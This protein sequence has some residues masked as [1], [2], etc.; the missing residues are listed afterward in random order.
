MV[1]K[2]AER[3]YQPIPDFTISE[4]EIKKLNQTRDF[5]IEVAKFKVTGSSSDLEGI[6][7]D[8]GHTF[9]YLGPENE[10]D[11]ISIEE[12]QYLCSCGAVAGIKAISK[13]RDSGIFRTRD[14]G[15]LATGKAKDQSH[16]GTVIR[17]SR[18]NH[19]LGLLTEPST[20][21][22]QAADP[23]KYHPVNFVHFKYELEGGQLGKIQRANSDIS[24][25]STL[26]VIESDTNTTSMQLDPA[27]ALTSASLVTPAEAAPESDNEPALEY[28]DPP[29]SLLDD[30][31]Q[32]E[33]LYEF[34]SQNLDA[35]S[36][37]SAWGGEVDNFAL[38][39]GHS[40]RMLRLVPPIRWS[41]LDHL[42]STSM[43]RISKM[44]LG[45]ED[46]PSAVKAKTNMVAQFVALPQ[47]NQSIILES[48]SEVKLESKLVP[49]TKSY[50]QATDSPPHSGRVLPPLLP[51]DPGKLPPPPPSNPAL[52][53]FGSDKTMRCD[54]V[55][56]CSAYATLA[57]LWKPVP[58][59]L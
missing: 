11:G 38:F 24:F 31:S 39:G 17:E 15:C 2:R 40:T 43:R 51:I 26:G 4:R 5:C 13:R 50:P 57:Q 21:L 8:I 18:N 1:V 56:V 22:L 55:M 44:G 12:K 27:T 19:A 58:L 20:E 46:I 52:P 10:Y 34:N 14:P 25:A 36:D 59:R 42:V 30:F 54:G 29:A 53:V 16:S 35:H 7:E 9:L 28:Y 48:Q 37:G 33:D 23:S 49:T 45:F 3:H 41:E 6:P 32:L 47:R